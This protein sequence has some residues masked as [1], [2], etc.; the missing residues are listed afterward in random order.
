MRGWQV[1]FDQLFERALAIPQR[2][3][4]IRVHL[5]GAVPSIELRH[6]LERLRN[7]RNSSVECVHDSHADAEL[8]E[9]HSALVNKQLWPNIDNFLSSAYH[10]ESTANKHS[11]ARA[12]VIRA[13]LDQVP[14]RI[15]H[16]KSWRQASGARLDARTATI[17]D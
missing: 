2:L 14:I 5:A 16:I 15:S 12:S 3:G 9:Q 8:F 17:T 4:H 1:L 13:N 7:P 10:G 6:L 11:D